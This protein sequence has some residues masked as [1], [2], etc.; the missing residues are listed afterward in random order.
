MTGTPL[1]CLCRMCEAHCGLLADGPPVWPAAP[2]APIQL[3][4]DPDHPLSRGYACKKGLDFPQRALGPRRVTSARI[5]SGETLVPAAVGPTL[6]AAGARIAELRRRHGPES[7]ALFVGNATAYSGGATLGADLFRRALGTRRVYSSLTLDNAPQLLVHDLCLG[8]P[9]RT[10]VADYSGADCILLVGTDPLAS[11]ASQSQSHPH[12]V[13][14]LLRK[15]EALIVVDPR[16]STTAAH[17]GLHMAARAG[18]DVALLA[19][20]VRGVLDA[21]PRPGPVALPP[22]QRQ[23]LAELC[24][25]YTP[26]RVSA[27]TGLDLPSLDLLLRRLLAARRP[28]VWSGLGVLLGPEGSVGWWLTLAL[29]TA[30]GGLGDTWRYQP[31]PVGMADLTSWLGLRHDPQNRSRIGGY[32]AVLGHH[33][34]ATLAEDVLSEDPDRTRALVV[35]GGNPAVS[36]PGSDSAIRALQR[37]ELLVVI[38]PFESRT[39]DLAHYTFPATTWLERPDLCLAAA[40]LRSGPETLEQPQLRCA[41]GESRDDWDWLRALAAAAGRPFGGSALASWWIGDQRPEALSRRLLSLRRLWPVKPAL[42]LPA[43]DLCPES[44][45]A[46]FQAR[47][48][49]E[50]G[51]R[52]VSSARQIG[53]MNTW[54]R[55]KVV[56]TGRVHPDHVPPSGLLRVRGREGT[57]ELR[58]EPDA[59]LPHETLVLPWGDDETEGG[60]NSNRLVDPQ[61]REP[62]TGQPCA[63]GGRI[64]V[65]PG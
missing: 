54:I 15:R 44:L 6:S 27:E 59:A 1:R 65:E 18:S 10:F 39:T 8:S 33:A 25:G 30:L 2:D 38:D 60:V 21:P 53:A 51:W 7:I 32:A 58:V 23:R 56:R 16:R 43:L 28:L 24:A 5:R 64:E 48:P 20:L 13:R 12:A 31:G 35:I 11:Q 37:L 49:Q 4:P 19:G 41:P 45:I 63:N 29:Q 47:V 3:R 14:D 57:V 36:L 34:A 40:E 55:P 50:P 42:T 17:A 52:L 26:E 62:L 9:L 22:Q 61:A 46:A